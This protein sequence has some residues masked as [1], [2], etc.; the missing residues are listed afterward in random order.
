[1]FA[2]DGSETGRKALERLTLSPLLQGLECDLVMVGGEAQA[3]S[4]AQG[5]LQSAG[6][7]VTR[8]TSYNVCYTKLLRPC[9][10]GVGTINS[11]SSYSE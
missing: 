4:E 2:Y 3:L 11:L 9:I 7:A 10:F 5:L 6:L 8:I 1:M